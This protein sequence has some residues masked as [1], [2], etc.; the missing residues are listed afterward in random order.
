MPYLWSFSGQGAW[1]AS[2]WLA[3]PGQTGRVPSSPDLRAAQQ[4]TRSCLGPVMRQGEQ[5]GPCPG[6]KTG[7]HSCRPVAAQLIDQE[8]G[9]GI[10]SGS[11]PDETERFRHQDGPPKECPFSCHPGSIVFSNA[12]RGEHCLF[13]CRL[14]PR[15]SIAFRPFGSFSSLTVLSFSGCPGCPGCHPA[16]FSCRA[17]RGFGNSILPPPDPD[18]VRIAGP[19]QEMD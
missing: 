5:T 13:Q 12:G 7:A 6:G 4:P 18:G 15:R 14:L 17:E 9:R 16:P 1:P 2:V 8:P 10:G 3:G 19:A 11:C